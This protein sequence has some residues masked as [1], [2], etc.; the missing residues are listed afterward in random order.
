M[1]IDIIW[2]LEVVGHHNHEVND[3]LLFFPETCG[4]LAASLLKTISKC[5]ITP[6]E[7]IWF[8]NVIDWHQ[9]TSQA[10]PIPGPWHCRSS[11]WDYS[12]RETH[13]SH[14]SIFKDSPNYVCS[15]TFPSFPII[16]MWLQWILVS[17]AAVIVI[18]STGIEQLIYNADVSLLS[19]CSIL[20]LQTELK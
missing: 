1:Y 19:E 15:T 17:R 8:S 2:V 4:N 6:E 3:I 20:N 13:M 5:A 7:S 10:A 16:T 14:H 11:Q 18:C 9:F 12:A